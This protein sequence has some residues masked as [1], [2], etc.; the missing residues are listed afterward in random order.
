[1]QCRHFGSYSH[2]LTEYNSITNSSGTNSCNNKELPWLLKIAAAGS[3]PVLCTSAIRQLPVLLL[4]RSSMFAGGSL[5]RIFVAPP[6]GR[7]SKSQEILL[8]QNEMS[9]LKTP[10]KSMLLSADEDILMSA[11][12]LVLARQL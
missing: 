7:E 5:T 11:S 2:T 3:S 4:K 12:K 9:S 6:V 10:S 8:G 1:M